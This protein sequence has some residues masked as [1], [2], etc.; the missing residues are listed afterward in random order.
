MGGDYNYMMVPT[1]MTMNMHMIGAMYGLTDRFTIMGMIHFIQHNMDIERRMG[2][3]RRFSTESQ[4]LGDMN[5][6]AF[7]N[8]KPEPH[9]EWVVG[10]GLSLPSGEI[11][12]EDDTPMGGNTHLPYSMQLGSGT[13]DLLPSL[14]YRQSLKPISWGTQVNATLRLGENDNEYTL[15]NRLNLQAW[16]QYQ[17]SNT[18]SLSLRLQLEDWDKIDGSDTE[19]TMMPSMNPNADPDLRGGQRLDFGFGLSA[20]FKQHQL[21]IEYLLPIHQNLDGP[22]MGVDSTLILGYRFGH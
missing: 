14:T 15:G 1:K 7:Y 10:F 22:Q 18:L 19:L 21:S 9:R 13:V 4:G 3:P 20:Q 11:D 17:A 16:Y 6:S 8:L 12:A 2:T 5:I